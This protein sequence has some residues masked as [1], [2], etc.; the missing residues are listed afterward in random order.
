MKVSSDEAIVEIVDIMKRLSNGR[1][2]GLMAK[3]QLLL[4]PYFPNHALV[5]FKYTS[6]RDERH[7]VPVGLTLNST[8]SSASPQMQPPSHKT[9]PLP[10]FGGLGQQPPSQNVPLAAGPV[11][12]GRLAL[13][14]S[15]LPQD[16]VA[17]SKG[18]GAPPAQLQSSLRQGGKGGGFP[19]SLSNLV[20]QAKTTQKK[21][22]VKNK[23]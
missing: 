9:M 17:V 7:G 4:T 10:S 22:Q 13:G 3:E 18:A 20:P 19:F 16:P 5:L 21:V 15:G 12:P 14:A 23:P 8:E 2:T 11:P 1:R 6:H